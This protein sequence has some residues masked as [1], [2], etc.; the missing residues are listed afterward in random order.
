MHTAVPELKSMKCTWILSSV[1]MSLGL[2]KATRNLIL[3]LLIPKFS[4]ED[5]QCR[6]PG[7]ELSGMSQ[8][9]DI[10][11][12]LILP[13]HMDNLYQQVFF[14]ERPPV[15]TCTNFYYE[16]Y[17]QFQTVMF[18][19]QEIN[20]NPDILSNISLGF[21][22]H[23]SCGLLQQSVQGTFQVLTGRSTAIPNYRCTGNVPLSAVIGPSAS[24]HSIIMAHILGLH[25]FPQISHFSTSP[26]LSD[27]YRFPSFFRTIPIQVMKNSTATVVI[28]FCND[29]NLIPILDEML[30]RK[31]SKKTFVASEAWSTSTLFNMNKYSGLLIGTLG[32][33]IPHGTIPE[34]QQSTPIYD[35]WR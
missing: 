25:Q 13:V 32:L 18:A 30:L 28:I 22:A 34:L 14:N 15:T 3:L 12:G 27:S 5:Q 2:Y 23:D 24:T 4:S 31:I 9:G 21:Q 33:A 8:P 10:M 26:I 7:T 17:Q 29:L 19:I 20:S 1:S 35:F 16:G 6:L 11:V